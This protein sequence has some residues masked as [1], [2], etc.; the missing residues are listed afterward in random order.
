[1]NRRDIWTIVGI[2]L[3]TAGLIFLPSPVPAGD[4]P[5]ENVVQDVVHKRLW[6]QDPEEYFRL[7]WGA[8][9]YRQF[10]ARFGAPNGLSIEDYAWRNFDDL[11]PRRHDEWL[12]RYGRQSERLAQRF[13]RELA[14]TLAQLYERNFLT[15]IAW[16][17]NLGTLGSGPIS[18]AILSGQAFATLV[19]LARNDAHGDIMFEIDDLSPCFFPFCT[20]Y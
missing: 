18:S 7:R 9:I 13:D 12:Y 11:L 14:D 8:L 6:S 15:Y 17:D 19:A 4:Q 3:S 5:I 1:M 16:L 10:Q 2:T 20:T